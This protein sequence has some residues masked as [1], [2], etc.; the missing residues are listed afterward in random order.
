MTDLK[1]QY[2]HKETGENDDEDSNAKETLFQITQDEIMFNN[3]KCRM[4]TG[5][6]IT[7]VQD[8]IRLQEEYNA[9]KLMSS[10]IS[11][12]MITPLRCMSQL[13]ENISVESRLST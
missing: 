11:H 1:Y 5:T 4:V 13:T 6:D 3:K 9:I 10:F 8:N 12:E 7:K 2:V